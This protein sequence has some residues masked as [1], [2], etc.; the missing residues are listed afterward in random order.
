MF[1]TTPIIRSI[2]QAERPVTRRWGY[3]NRWI[4]TVRYLL[5]P[6]SV[7]SNTTPVIG[8]LE[9]TQRPVTR[10][11]RR[12]NN[13]M[14]A[15]EFES[16]SPTL[17]P[18]ASTPAAKSAPTADQT[19]VAALQRQ[20]DTAAMA[21]AAERKRQKIARAQKQIASAALSH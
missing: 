5:F 19:R 15:I 10:R 7:V 18:T 4:K 14:R 6:Q 21:L 13:C 17:Q 16:K 11:W 9:N 20:K 8:S 1:N 2:E 12:I 3:I